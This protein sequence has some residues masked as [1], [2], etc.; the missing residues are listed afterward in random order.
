MEQGDKEKSAGRMCEETIASEEIFRGALVTVRRE[1]V[2]LPDGRRATREIV[3]HAPAVAILPV[4]AQGR[5]LLV[6]QYRK[7]LE[8]VL[9]E[10]PAGKMEAGEAP[11]ECAR[12]EL[13][14]EAGV[15]AGRLVYLG[16]IATTPGFSDEIIHLFRAEE[17]R[18]ATGVA[19]DP[20]E[21]LEAAPVEWAEVE[22]MVERGELWD[23]KS[24][25]LVLR[26]AARRRSWR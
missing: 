24:L 1:T 9:W 4:D 3:E 5:V 6:R 25:C 7:P 10:V 2:R 19:G 18:P 11:E 21:A 20:D 14:E 23:A 26:E 15:A 8:Q 16:K 22:R 13:A 17:L 12:R